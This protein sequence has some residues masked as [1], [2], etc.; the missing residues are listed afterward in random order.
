MDAEAVLFDSCISVW[1]GCMLGCTGVVGP[2][3]GGDVTGD[4]DGIMSNRGFL[5]LFS[6][7]ERTT[8]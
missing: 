6:M 2:A 4:N 3:L 7:S 1:C 5:A 8:C